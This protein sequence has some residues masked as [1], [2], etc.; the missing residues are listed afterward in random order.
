MNWQQDLSWWVHFILLT[1]YANSCND[2]VICQL[3]RTSKS[4]LLV[5]GLLI[6]VM[7]LSKVHVSRSSNF[8]ILHD[9]SVRA[10]KVGSVTRNCDHISR[11]VWLATE[12]THRG[13]NCV[14]CVCCRWCA[15]EPESPAD[16]VPNSTA[17][18]TQPTVTRVGS[19]QPSLGRR[20]V[21]PR[22]QKNQHCTAPGSYIQR[23]VAHH[24]R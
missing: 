17:Q 22:S 15:S 18:G 24:P 16:G 1:L 14:P 3:I 2:R 5:T 13:S 8:A 19:T 11:K 12:G 4:P 6:L 21:V 9:T 7:C 23:V 20:A 10:I